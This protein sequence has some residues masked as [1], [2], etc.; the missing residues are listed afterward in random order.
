MTLSDL[1]H[2]IADVAKAL[3][4]GAQVVAIFAVLIYALARLLKQPPGSR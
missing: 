3:S 1:L 2:A 4:P